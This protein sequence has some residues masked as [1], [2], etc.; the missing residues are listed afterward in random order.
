MDKPTTDLTGRVI[1]VAA[2]L[3]VSG[4]I[5]DEKGE[6]LPGVSVVIKGT[7]KGTTTDTDGKFRLSVPETGNVT[8]VFSFVGYA[9]QEVAVGNR[10]VIDVKLA[11]DD[12]TLSEVVVV[13]YG[14]Q[15][16]S[17]LTGA[18]A[19]VSGDELTKLAPTN[20]QNALQGQ[21]AGVYVSQSSG[22]PGSGADI[23]IRGQT[24]VTGL[25]QV[26]YVVDGIP[27]TGNLNSINP[28]DI[29]SIEVLKDASAAAIY[30]SR[31]SSGVVLITTKRGKPKQTK[32]S[33]DAFYGTQQMSRKLDL[34]NGQEWAQ[35]I[36]QGVSNALQRNPTAS[37]FHNPDVWDAA[38]KQVRP[39][40]A[41]STDWQNAY[42]RSA[43]T[44][45]LLSLLCRRKREQ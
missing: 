20:V 34:M 11:S 40:L 33:F 45:E 6:T 25:N 5:T 36:E 35:T 3:T 39:N 44:P 31:A 16:K 8:L 12:K 4:R 19:Q 7:T 27:I 42:Y 23:I 37:A 10:S 1:S 43:P 15:K 26:L 41:D 9:S 13:G 14:V 30:G 28:Q 2:D 38:A 18:V 21:A 32:L 24:S 22:A 29:Q 17:D